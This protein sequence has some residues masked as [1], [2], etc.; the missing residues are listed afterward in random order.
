MHYSITNLALAVFSKLWCVFV[1]FLCA[2]CGFQH[3]LMP[4][5]KYHESYLFPQ[6]TSVQV[7]LACL[8]CLSDRDSKVLEMGTLFPGIKKYHEYAKKTRIN[9]DSSLSKKAK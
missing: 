1:D 8:V 5:S 4:L 6:N 9:L 2:V 3:P 7:Q